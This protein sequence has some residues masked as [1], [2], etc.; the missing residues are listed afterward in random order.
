MF[1]SALPL[2][3]AL[4][5]SMSASRVAEVE[6]ALGPVFDATPEGTAP[7]LQRY[8]VRAALAFVLA[9][10]IAAPAA[11]MVS[12]YGGGWGTEHAAIKLP[13][14]ADT[15][16]QQ[17]TDLFAPGVSLA[18]TASSEASATTSKDARS[19]RQN[20]AAAGA[21]VGGAG[22]S[23]GS[24]GG[25]GTP[26]YGPSGWSEPRSAS[27]ELATRLRRQPGTTRPSAPVVEPEPEPPQE[28]PQQPSEG[29]A[30]EDD[31]EKPGGK[32]QDKGNG[33][34]PDGPDDDGG[35]SSEDTP[36]ADD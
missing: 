1:E 20:A 26:S 11:A 35:G 17:S 3:A 9:I 31:G 30:D 23:W 29:G 13:P 27:S 32:G 34:K 5:S 12:S 8:S 22:E 25:A 7:A 16:P 28:P 14:P 18:S 6:A 21:A 33:R 2:H 10:T 24:E 19:S 4:G 36:S 15:E